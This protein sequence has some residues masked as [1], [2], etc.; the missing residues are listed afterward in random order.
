[1][2]LTENQKATKEV[3][4][5]VLIKAWEDENFK[6]ELIA[7]PSEAIEKFTGEK[8]SLKDGVNISVV[9]Q[10]DHNTF[11]FNIPAEPNAE[12]VE[13]TEEQL[14]MVAGGGLSDFL[15]KAAVVALLPAVIVYAYCTK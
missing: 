12:D 1:M 2:E 13:L 11:Y 7:T 5:Q 4:A 3:L 14:E 10:S 9:D 8:L 6:K 15:K